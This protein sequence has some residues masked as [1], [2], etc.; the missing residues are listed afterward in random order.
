MNFSLCDAYYVEILLT[1]DK[2]SCINLFNAFFVVGVTGDPQGAVD[3]FC[4]YQ[5]FQTVVPNFN[6]LS[7]RR[8]P[9]APT[10]L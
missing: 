9:V 1:A 3:H 10:A 2:F 7:R 8:S 5:L 6:Y 4:D